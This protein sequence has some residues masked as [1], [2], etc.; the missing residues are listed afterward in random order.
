MA[1]QSSGYSPQRNTPV[2]F[3]LIII[4]VLMLAAQHIIKEFDLTD[5]GALR[6]FKSSEFQPHQLVTNMFLH[7]QKGFGHIIF[8]MLALW[9]FGSILEKFWGSKR[10]LIFYLVCGL[11]ASVL[12]QFTIPFSAAQ[13]ASAQ[14]IPVEVV[15]EVYQAIG[16]SGAIMGVMAAFA[17]LFPNTE[18]FMFLIPI[19]IKAKF[20]IPIMALIDLFGGLYRIQGDNIGHF[21]HLGGALVGFLLVLYWNKNRKQFY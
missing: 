5:W 11:G 15:K 12:V 9:M 2:V 1:Y 18:L 6:Y 4:N 17:Y 10:F 3:N 13:I 19:P 8:N 21:A 16:A 7:D 20:A 14:G